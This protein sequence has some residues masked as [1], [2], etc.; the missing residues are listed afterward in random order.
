[1]PDAHRDGG[2]GGGWVY[3][4]PLP[5]ARRPT[6]VNFGHQMEVVS[7][8]ALRGGQHR[9]A[10]YGLRACAVAVAAA[11]EIVPRSSS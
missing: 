10:R 9:V 1:M 5:G 2:G 6:S 11:P 8:G 7:N 4:E 3:V